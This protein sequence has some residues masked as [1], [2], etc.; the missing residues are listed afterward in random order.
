MLIIINVNKLDAGNHISYKITLI[1]TYADDT[2]IL[3]SNVD[4]AI[5]RQQIQTH[6]NT[7]LSWFNKWRIKINE[8]KSS[9]ITFSLRPQDCPPR[10]C[11]CDNSHKMVYY[12]RDIKDINHPQGDWK[13]THEGG[14][15]LKYPNAP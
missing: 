6:L 7:L 10:Q 9:L 4:P 1:G 15:L 11:A 5:A 2:A 3:A 13:I 14:N 8:T 12:I